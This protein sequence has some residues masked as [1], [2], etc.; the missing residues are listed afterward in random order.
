MSVRLIATFCLS[1]LIGLL[2]TA[3]VAP[4]KTAH[5]NSQVT[6]PK[7]KGLVSILKYQEIA[8]EPPAGV[9]PDMAKLDLYRLDDN[10]PRP[11][12]L[13][14]HGGSWASGDKAGFT[15]KFVPWWVQQGYV[16]A[17]VNFRLASKFR[18]FP[19]VKPIDQ[20]EDIAAALAWLLT[21][22][23]KYQVATDK[24]VVLGYSS[25]AHLA[26]LLGT[27][28]RFLRQQGVDESK[29]TAVISLD[30][31]AYDVPYALDLMKGS[32]VENNI[33]II[34][35]LFGNTA[36]QQL[37]SSPIHYLDGWAAKALIVSVGKDPAVKGSHGYIVSEA[38]Q[39]Y[40]TALRNAGHLAEMFHDAGETHSSLV[41]GFGEPG[42]QVTEKIRTFLDGLE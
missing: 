21:N 16:V 28:E 20:A 13:L 29:L 40:A 18:A 5:A 27:D 30:V 3:C 10:K 24:V 39:R 41:G 23:K 37:T 25:G 6:T 19:V 36:Q 2:C 4:S 15:T 33:P 7:K 11:L 22:A 26:A 32:V 8:Y 38:A 34:Q 12:V 31:H 14:V 42:D 9:P 35:H 1:G 17:P